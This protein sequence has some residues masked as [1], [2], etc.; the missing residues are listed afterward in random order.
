MESQ[1][2]RNAHLL[3]A[4]EEQLDRAAMALCTGTAFI[5]VL[6]AAELRN[7]A[8][9]RL[10]ARVAGLKLPDPIEVGSPEEV[11]EALIEQIEAH[12]RVL[13][14][15]LANNVGG[16]LDGLNL[17]R[18]KVLKGPPVILWLEDVEALQ[19]TRE[20]APDA[21]SF[22]ST[23][24]V[25][26]GDGGAVPVPIQDPEFVT[27]ERRRLKRA[28]T[29]LDRA[30]VSH[31]LADALRKAGKLTEAEEVAHGGL[32]ALPPRADDDDSNLDVRLSLLIT[33]IAIAKRRRAW[34][35]ELRWVR[36]ALTEIDRMTFSLGLKRR[37]FVLA[38]Y[39]GAIGSLDR[40][41]AEAA[42]QLVRTYGLAPE[43]RSHALRSMSAVARDR[44]DLRRA[45]S[46]VEELKSLSRYENN[47]NISL[48][49]MEIGHVEMAIGRLHA[50]EEKFREYANLRA[51]EGFG[52]FAVFPLIDCAIAQGEIAKAERFLADYKSVSA[53]AAAAHQSLAAARITFAKGDA[54]SAIQSL[55]RDLHHALRDGRDGDSINLCRRY[56]SMVT[57]SHRVGL[58]GSK[59]LMNAARET[60]TVQEIF[61]SLAGLNGP[62]WC[63]I[64]LI[65]MRADLLVLDPETRLQALELARQALELAR[66]TY[67]DLIPF[68]GRTVADYLLRTGS[69]AS[70][71][72]LIE[73]METEADSRGFLRELASLRALRI[74][75]LVWRGTPLETIEQH[76]S[77]L[78]ATLG[79]TDSPRI[80]AEVLRDLAVGIPP[81]GAAP[82]PYALAEEAHSLFVAMPMPANEARCLEIMGDILFARG[83]APEA[84]RRYLTARARLERHGLGLR[85]PM[86]ARKIEALPQN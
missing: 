22:R 2:R 63:P 72:T 6:C 26:R 76:I 42:L 68:A 20:R 3:H 35:E 62:A 79:A 16:A 70:A 86:L 66:S 74:I 49:T 50:A 61:Q 69:L 53:D 25:L 55:E 18:E 83:R 9:E 24:V 58:L 85:L 73:E 67:P 41:S 15:A 60:A 29:P 52:S 39:P 40:T 82:D 30:A 43:Q 32:S 44:G 31:M 54:T 27:Q 47:F 78:R 37:V 23:M 48:A 59:E 34:I 75:A 77:A 45:R 81:I 71:L 12:E 14:L 46:L 57:G 33:L 17:H 80:I 56:C 8:L 84:K 1:A 19:K 11:L 36:Y 64:W 10:R 51:A 21:Y 38:N 7:A 28:R 65:G 13:S 4:D 5:V